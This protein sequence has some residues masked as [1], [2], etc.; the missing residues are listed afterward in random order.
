MLGKIVLGA[1]VL[2]VLGAAWCSAADLPDTTDNMVILAQDRV[3]LLA[4]S[5]LNSGQIAVNNGGGTVKVHLGVRAFEDTEIIAD[6]VTVKAP[7]NRK[8]RLFDVFTNNFRGGNRA[9]VSDAVS[10]LSVPLPLYTLPP[11][12][13]FTPGADPCPDGTGTRTLGNCVVRRNNGPVTL[14]PGNYGNI[15]VRGSGVLYLQGGTYNIRSLHAKSYSVIVVNGSA[16]VNVQKNVS[17][18]WFSVFEPINGINPRCVVLNVEGRHVWI[19]RAT[20]SAVINA[21]NAAVTVGAAWDYVGTVYTGNLV[22]KRV[23]VGPYST[24]Q[25]ADPLESTC[26][27]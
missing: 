22:G 4:Y 1:A 23:S 13:V 12:P 10:P 6:N 5:K 11:L 26:P 27:Q 2:L 24:L 14:P 8:P 18:S 19:D 7:Y 15:R 9:I 21:P 3:A 17:L 20:I 16:T 25:P